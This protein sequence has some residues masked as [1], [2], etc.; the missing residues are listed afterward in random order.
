MHNKEFIFVNHTALYLL[1]SC[2]VLKQFS[3]IYIAILLIILPF[4]PCIEFKAMQQVKKVIK[5]RRIKE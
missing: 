2:I 1:T 4:T 3:K 5:G